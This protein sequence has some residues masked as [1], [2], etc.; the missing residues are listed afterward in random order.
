M[1]LYLTLTKKNLSLILAAII[2]FFILIGQFVTTSS[3]GIDGS[4]NAK[5]VEYL[6]GLSLKVNETAADIKDIV[7]PEK[8]SKVYKEYNKLQERAGFNLENFKGK[9]AKVYTYKLSD[10]SESEV[11][12]IICN[13][14]IIGG[15]IASIK[16]DGEMLP[17]KR[18]NE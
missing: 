5:R 16:I 1:K 9:P 11:H 6:N 17:L 2:I 3:G 13:D 15:D 8:F 7:I 4:T 18:K 14:K 12:L 10:D